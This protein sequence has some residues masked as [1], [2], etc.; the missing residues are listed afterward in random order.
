MFPIRENADNKHP[1]ASWG[2]PPGGFVDIGCGNGLLT[3]ILIAEGYE[4]TGFDI[5][6]RTSWS[7][8]SNATQEKLLVR[9]FDPFQLHSS[10]TTSEIFPPGC[11]IIANHADELTPWAPLISTKAGASGYFS[12]PCCAWSFDQKFSKERDV[13]N[14]LDAEQYSLLNLGP[15]G[16]GSSYAKYRIWLGGVSWNAG[17]E[18]ECDTLRIPS[19]RNWAIV[20]VF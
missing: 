20:G 5:R 7:H 3:H 16:T 4:G 17:W 9:A 2:R 1:C 15:Q 18:I 19:T 8:Y 6:A 11:F 14:I 12:L 10:E 13:G